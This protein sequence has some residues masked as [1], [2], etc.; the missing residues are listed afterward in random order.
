MLVHAWLGLGQERWLD[1]PR[2][3]VSVSN[4]HLS[5][6]RDPAAFLY[7]SRAHAFAHR[8]NSCGQT[9]DQ[10]HCRVE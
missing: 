1:D 4:D 5:A 2:M 8:T 6:E 10:S 7:S 3:K 9:M